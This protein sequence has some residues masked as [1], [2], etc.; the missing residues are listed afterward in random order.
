[1]QLNKMMDHNIAT[2]EK[3]YNLET[4]VETIDVVLKA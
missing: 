4:V 1:M 3:C 2:G